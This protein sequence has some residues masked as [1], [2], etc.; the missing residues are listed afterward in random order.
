MKS[1]FPLSDA[2]DRLSENALPYGL[3]IVV[4]VA[5]PDRTGKEYRRG[6]KTSGAR[7][8]DFRLRFRPDNRGG[9]RQVSAQNSMAWQLRK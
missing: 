6:K 1:R 5:A 4:A 9:N 2:D 3:G 8:G 7:K